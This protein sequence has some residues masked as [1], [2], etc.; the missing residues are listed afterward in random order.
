ME[1]INEVAKH[2][3]MQMHSLSSCQADLELIIEDMEGKRE[4]VDHELH[5]NR[6]G[7][8]YISPSS[9]KIKNPPFESGV[10]KIQNNDILD[11]TVE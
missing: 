10:I 5:G 8:E 11:M 1:R 9:S 2:L 4:D 3:Q 6:L 7:K